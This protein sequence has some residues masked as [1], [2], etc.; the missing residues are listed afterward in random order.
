VPRARL[1]SCIVDVEDWG[2]VHTIVAGPMMSGAAT[3]SLINNKPPPGHDVGKVENSRCT[4][5]SPQDYGE[6]QT[7]KTPKSGQAGH[8]GGGF[9]FDPIATC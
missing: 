2:S 4:L 8:L 5:S 7:V 9:T 1:A 6:Y 3:N